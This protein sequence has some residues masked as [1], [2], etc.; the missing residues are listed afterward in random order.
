M[1]YFTN[2]IESKF[3]KNLLGNLKRPVWMGMP[4]CLE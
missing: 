2:T 1:Q 4:R 3:I